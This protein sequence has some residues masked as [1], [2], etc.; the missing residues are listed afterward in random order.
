VLGVAAEASAEEV[1]AAYRARAQALHPD[2]RRRTDPAADAEMAAV[3][4]A[5]STLRDPARRSAYDRSLGVAPHQAAAATGQAPRR[6]AHDPPPVLDAPPGCLSPLAS[7]GP[8][9][10]VLAVL[11]AIF[12]FTAYAASDREAD[13]PTAT[14]GE[15]DVSMT[16]VR[17]LRGSCIG[18]ANGATIVVD[19]FTVPHEGLIVAQASVGSSC[20][21]GTVEWLIR[22]QDVLACTQPGSEARAP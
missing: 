3:N 8:W 2:R 13:D 1:R 16:R 6:P 19:C 10:L 17:D 18:L 9:M 4:D 15:A 20:P 7:V 12:V 11:A 5:W 22:Q 14:S 21:E